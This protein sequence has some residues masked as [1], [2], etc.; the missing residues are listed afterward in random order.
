MNR[1]KVWRFNCDFCHRGWFKEQK[2]L[3]H[4]RVC[5]QNPG[6]VCGLCERYGIMQQPMFV[7]MTLL[8]DG[9]LDVDRLRYMAHE[10]PM[11]MLAAVMAVNKR[12]GWKR[13]SEDYWL[14]DYPA[15][16]KRFDEKH[17]PDFKDMV[18][19]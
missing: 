9:D 6:R 19:T 14:F 3:A 8:E 5:V 15:E 11:C 7:M 13:S 17:N 18:E 10:C 12:E 1:R 2:C 16:M 4:E